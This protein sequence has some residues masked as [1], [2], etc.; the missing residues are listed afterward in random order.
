MRKKTKRTREAQGRRQQR[1]V[2]LPCVNCNKPSRV[3]RDSL[4]GWTV[5]PTCDC[6]P[7]AQVSWWSKKQLLESLAA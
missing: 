2:R 4:G 6:N 7:A 3:V 1:V 5:K